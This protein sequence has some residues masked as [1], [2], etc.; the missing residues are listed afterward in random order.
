[1]A[2]KRCWNCMV[3]TVEGVSCNLGLR[4][5]RRLC[6]LDSKRFQLKHWALYKPLANAF[7]S[8]FTSANSCRRI[9][10]LYIEICRC[11][12]VI[13]NNLHNK[14]VR[15]N[16]PQLTNEFNS[17]K[18]VPSRLISSKLIGISF[19]PVPETSTTMQGDNFPGKNNSSRS[20]SLIFFPLSY[21]MSFIHKSHVEFKQRI[22]FNHELNSSISLFLLLFLPHQVFLICHCYKNVFSLLAILKLEKKEKFLFKKFFNKSFF[23]HMV[24]SRH[25]HVTDR[26]LMQGMFKNV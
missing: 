24:L 18:N 20:P 5:Q 2:N 26:S 15:I 13:F 6:R 11:L 17:C 8:L 12:A 21:L 22:A 23:F 4:H 1:M 16:K 19:I 7:L 25:V 14:S 3:L 9:L 10:V